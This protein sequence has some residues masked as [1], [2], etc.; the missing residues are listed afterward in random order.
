MN[1]GSS[2]SGGLFFITFIR[3]VM[4]NKK[5]MLILPAP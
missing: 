3:E 1:E 5:I 2:A 4:K